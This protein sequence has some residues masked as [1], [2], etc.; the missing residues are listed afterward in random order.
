ETGDLRHVPHMVAVARVRPNGLAVHHDGAG[1]GVY[2]PEQALDH[3]GLARSVGSDHGNGLAGFET[4]TELAQRPHFPVLL[5]DVLKDYAC[6]AVISSRVYHPP[7]PRVSWRV[8]SVRPGPTIV[9]TNFAK[10][11]RHMACARSPWRTS[12]RVGMVHRR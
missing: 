1:G 8:P 7:S 3:G 5:A 10:A 2:Q 12:S 4:R 11:P 9:S 6:H